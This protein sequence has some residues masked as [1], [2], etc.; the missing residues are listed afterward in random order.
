MQQPCDCGADCAGCAAI[1]S[2]FSARS[3]APGRVAHDDHGKLL[4][5]TGVV[6]FSAIM[7]SL[8]CCRQLL[9]S[10]PYQTLTGLAFPAACC[11]EVGERLLSNLSTT[12]KGHV[13]RWGKWQG[14]ELLRVIMLWDI[15]SCYVMSCHNNS[16]HVVSCAGMSFHPSNASYMTVNGA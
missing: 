9:Q 7:L 5:S 1:G 13:L 15:T 10:A 3:T 4:I 12:L 8:T 16:C 14:W 6:L 2:H 11:D